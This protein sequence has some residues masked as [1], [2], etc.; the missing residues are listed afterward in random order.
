MRMLLLRF[1]LFMCL[2]LVSCEGVFALNIINHYSPR[3]RERPKRR[4]TYYIIL[5]TT[6]G[7]KKGS[8]N[9][10]HARGEAHYFVDTKGRIYRIIDKKRVALHA[11]RSMWQGR[12]NI[13]NYSIGIEMVG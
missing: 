5:H 13:D 2:L 7:P 10:V 11:G 1:F 6:E 12:T 8:L 3:N 9:K 4:A